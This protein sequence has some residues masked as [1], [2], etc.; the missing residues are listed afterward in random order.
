VRTVRIVG[1]IAVLVA[2]VSVL[3]TPLA[4]TQAKV[5]TNPF[6]TGRTLN[7]AHGGGD[8]LFPEN[9]LFA[10]EQSALVGSEVIDV[11]VRL[12]KDGQP[13]AIHDF[14][15]ER[16]TNGVGRVDAMTVNEL[17][18]L[19]A[20]YRFAKG[21]KFPFRGKGVNIPTLE[22]LLQRFPKTLFSLDLK[23]ERVS[24]NEP[25]CSVLRKY[26]RTD[27]VFVGSN[28]DAQILAFRKSCVGIR[29]SAT[30]VDVFASERARETNDPNFVPDVFVDQPPYRINGRALVDADS[31]KFHHRH[32][33]A[34][35]TWVVDDPKDMKKLVRLGVDGIYTR[36]PDLL[37]K[38]LRNETKR[39]VTK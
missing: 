31:L 1:G 3:M 38:V 11:D 13:V 9:T 35:L 16:T 22:E 12:S 7:I 39:K 18:S 10:Y 34:I 37:A 24:M 14:T 4:A 25:V 5:P 23:D 36:R 27:D 17:K 19:D 6:R 8:A 20:G 30:M 28:N 2:I 32:G 33:V 29:T 26:K 15:V 21:S